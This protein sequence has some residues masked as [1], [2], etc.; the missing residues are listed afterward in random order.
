MKYPPKKKKK[1]TLTKRPE[2]SV[3]EMASY[4]QLAKKRGYTK[5]SLT[6]PRKETAVFGFLKRPSVC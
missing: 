4:Q 6:E 3:Y 2:D 5:R 1:K